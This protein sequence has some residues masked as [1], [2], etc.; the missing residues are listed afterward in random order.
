MSQANVSAEHIDISR[1]LAWFRIQTEPGQLR[2]W[3]ELFHEKPRLRFPKG[4]TILQQS[5]P[6]EHLYYVQSG[7]VEYIYCDPDGNE[8]LIDV[9]AT[10]HIL[11]LPSLFSADK[12]AMGNLNALSRV[13]LS[14]MPAREMYHYIETDPVLSKELLEESS[15]IVGAMAMQAYSKSIPAESRII[16]ALYLLAESVAK[17]KPD[18]QTAILLTISQ[19]ELARICHTTRV[20]ATKTLKKLKSMGLVDTTYRN[21]KVLDRAALHMQIAASSQEGTLA[22]SE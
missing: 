16:Q 1:P 22:Q 4:A 21:I 18:R 12:L 19:N 2:H 7:F 10:G 13:E 9:M 3:S 15:R 11:G 14:A 8:H 5:Q 17:S 6:V 20:T